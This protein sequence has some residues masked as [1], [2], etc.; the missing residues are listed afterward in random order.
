MGDYKKI[1]AL[2]GDIDS[3]G[4]RSFLGHTFCLSGDGNFLFSV[5][6]DRNNQDYSGNVIVRKFN[7]GH[8]EPVGNKILYNE[9][10]YTGKPT[11]INNINSNY[12]GSIFVMSSI[13]GTDDGKLWEGWLQVYKLN[14]N[15]NT[16]DKMGDEMRGQNQGDNFGWDAILNNSGNSLIVSATQDRIG[17]GKVKVYNYDNSTSHWILKGNEISGLEN[18]SLN[19][20]GIAMTNDSNTIIIG[21]P[22]KNRVR[23]FNYEND[24]WVNVEILKD[25][26]LYNTYDRFGSQIVCNSDASL[27]AIASPH[28]GGINFKGSGKISIFKKTNNQYTKIQE[29]IGDNN[30][31]NLGQQLGGTGQNNDSTKTM[32][33]SDD[34][35]L[36]LLGSSD[37][38]L[39]NNTK[40]G[41][42]TL[43]K[44]NNNNYEQ[45]QIFTSDS[46]IG[47]G[48]V[49]YKFNYIY[50]SLSSNG[51][52][53]AIGDRLLYNEVGGIDIYEKEPS[54]EELK[55][56]I[57]ELNNIVTEK[58]NTIQTLEYDYSSINNTLI[59]TQSMLAT[60]DA[61]LATTKSDLENKKTELANTQSTLA[62]TKSDLENKKTEL[63]NT[64]STLATTKADLKT[65]QATLETTYSNLE[66][67]KSHLQNTKIQLNNTK[68]DLNTAN[69]N[70]ETTKTHLQSTQVTLQNTQT[71][72]ATTKSNLENTK[73]HL[74]TTKVQLNNTKTDLENKIH[75]I[76]LIRNTLD[77]F[78]NLLNY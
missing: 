45:V 59:T 17:N 55:Q 28:Y 64:Q 29:I 20:K 32:D 71:T 16:W 74:N 38:W 58:N 63:A 46:V 10:M 78:K 11:I 60:S 15:T 57:E 4:H 61:T 3:Y 14:T 67:T 41:Y 12:D 27:I 69:A 35:K 36:L 39:S 18:F 30:N 40:G 53:L 13:Y 51:N 56:R 6:L 62:T 68:S 42:V 75:E 25:T 24:E 9:V 37:G 26:N 47:Q 54:I 70:L 1:I 73:S 77:Q 7:N 52:R 76:T 72:L 21:S 43:Y 31:S 23:I 50:C 44:L 34:G 49:D 2:K 33:M 66:N 19:G 8:W 22:N 48:G 65:T 5:E